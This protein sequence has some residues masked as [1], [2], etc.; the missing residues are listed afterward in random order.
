M[1]IPN[2]TCEDLGFDYGLEFGSELQYQSGQ[3]DW[4]SLDYAAYIAWPLFPFYEHFL[5]RSGLPVGMIIVSEM[6]S[7]GDN[8]TVFHSIAPP[9]LGIDGTDAY[10]GLPASR[11]NMTVGPAGLLNTPSVVYMCANKPV[12]TP[13]A[14]NCSAY[15]F[16][17]QLEFGPAKA[18]D[19]L[20][21]PHNDTASVYW[22]DW[23]DTAILTEFLWRSTAPVGALIYSEL[24]PNGTTQ[25]TLR[26]LSG[27]ESYGIG[28]FEDGLEY[29]SVGLTYDNATASWYTPQVIYMCSHRPMLTPNTT[30]R[31]LGYEY[32]VDFDISVPWQRREWNWPQS[33]E[34]AYLVWPA[35]PLLS[36]FYWRSDI[37]VSAIIISEMLPSGANTTTVMTLDPPTTGGDT[38]FVND[39]C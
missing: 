18:N 17:Y 36:V 8:I 32:S 26:L 16:H 28:S 39:Y 14:Y 20:P 29:G 2:T 23:S 3:W 15:G 9:S 27:N 37:N 30:C 13:P 6:T 38:F 24:D 31:D 35:F 11:V 4:P 7:N 1:L 34:A 12:F 22:P 5:W 21:W 33:L 19:T 10:N 25:T